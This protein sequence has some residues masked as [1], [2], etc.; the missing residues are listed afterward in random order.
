[1]SVVERECV[2]KLVKAIKR[3]NSEGLSKEEQDAAYELLG[4][5]YALFDEKI[6]DSE[7][8]TVLIS[9]AQEQAEMKKEREEASSQISDSE[10][11]KMFKKHFL[12][13]TSNFCARMQIISR[14]LK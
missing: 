11:V 4:D 7:R 9:H 2:E 10:F 14:I 12:L 6:E 3:N 13:L 1:M 8:V 5:A